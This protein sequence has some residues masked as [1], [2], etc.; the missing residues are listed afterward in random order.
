MAIFIYILWRQSSSNAIKVDVMY[1]VVLNTIVFGVM[2]ITVETTLGGTDYF[3]MTLV[4]LVLTGATTSF[5]Q[6]AVFAEASRFPP[7]YVQA[8]M[9]GQGI[10]GVAVAVSSLLSALAGTTKLETGDPSTNRSAFIY[11]VSA[12]LTTVAALVGRVMLSQQPFYIYQMKLDKTMNSEEGLDDDDDDELSTAEQ[13]QE[14]HTPRPLRQLVK[15]S[16]GLIVAVAYIFVITLMMFPTITSLIKSVV[17]HPPSSSPVDSAIS[18]TNTNDDSGSNGSR[19]FDDDIFV[20]MHFLLF[21]VGDWAG[22]IFPLWPTFRTFNPTL[23]VILS[24]LRTIFVPLFLVCNVVVSTERNLPVLV[25][26]D[27]LY[28]VLIWIFAV[29]NGW[30]SSLTM[31]AAPQQPYLRSAAEKSQIGSIMSFSLVVGLAIGGCL[32]FWARSMV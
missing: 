22:R 10:A 17:R 2:A 15:K 32:S 18:V 31:M 5:F 27:V 25:N 23:L 29:S 24:A 8:V 7:Q 9:S 13:Q 28:F 19:F 21:N 11:F 26:S 16:F 1:P 14:Q 6:V 4:L 30:I 12:L 3:W 20:A